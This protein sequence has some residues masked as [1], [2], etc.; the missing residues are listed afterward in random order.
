MFYL[1]LNPH[2]PIQFSRIPRT[3]TN[4][5]HDD[6]QRWQQRQQQ[7]WRPAICNWQRQQSIRVVNLNEGVFE[8]RTPPIIVVV[9]VV[10]TYLLI[11]F[12]NQCCILF[13]Y[14]VF[15][16]FRGKYISPLWR[17]VM[18]QKLCPTLVGGRDVSF[19][20][21]SGFD[22]RRPNIYEQIQF[23]V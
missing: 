23:L 20:L 11:T 14:L 12:F 10:F 1:S 3:S 5:G 6:Q 4:N 16:S 21:H 22:F 18:L 15:F 19:N 7:V 17:G 8:Y 2:F 13:I 9:V